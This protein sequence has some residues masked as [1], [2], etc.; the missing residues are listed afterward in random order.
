MV[1]SKGSNV[2]YSKISITFSDWMIVENIIP[3]NMIINLDCALVDN[4]IPQVDIFDRH[5]IREFNIYTIFWFF[6]NIGF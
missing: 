4:H 5:P 2:L 3:R 6:R 1:E